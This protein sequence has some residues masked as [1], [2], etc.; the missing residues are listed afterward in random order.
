MNAREARI[1]EIRREASDADALQRQARELLLHAVHRA[2]A[3]GFSQ[4]EVAQIVRRSQ[5][6]VSRLLHQKPPGPLAL[7][8]SRQRQSMT[9]A[10]ARYGVTD[11]RIFGSVA[12]RTETPGSDVDVLIDPPRVLGLGTLSR[13]ERELSSIL[14]TE[15]DVVP[16]QGLPLYMRERALAEAVPL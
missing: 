5:P 9:D 4:R 13:L 3:E 7:R 12:R 10:L 8:V 1:E 6:E 11:A 2:A 15:V 14:D 16:L